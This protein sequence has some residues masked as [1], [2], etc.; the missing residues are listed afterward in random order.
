MVIFPVA[1]AAAVGVGMGPPDEQAASTDGQGRRG[2]GG[3]QPPKAPGHESSSFRRR[4][5]SRSGSIG[6]R[7]NGSIGSFSRSIASEP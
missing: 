2:R 5:S 7:S 3:P 4:G 6:G 1:P